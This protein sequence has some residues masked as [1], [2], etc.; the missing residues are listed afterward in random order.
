MRTFELADEEQELAENFIVS[1]KCLEDSEKAYIDTNISYKF[2]QTGIGV[3]IEVSC[4]CG[5]A[6]NITDYSKW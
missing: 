2:T 5:E 3:A 6:E 1:H 4:G